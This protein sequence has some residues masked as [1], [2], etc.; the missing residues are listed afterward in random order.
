MGENPATMSGHSRTIIAMSDVTAADSHAFQVDLRGLVDLL[1]HHLYS[2]PRV[3]VRE[4]L[5]NAVDAVTARRAL[6]GETPGTGPGPIVRGCPRRNPS[7][8][9]LCNSK[10]QTRLPRGVGFWSPRTCHYESGSNPDALFDVP[11][12]SPSLDR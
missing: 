3:F 10:R 8:T 9:H 6:S 1:S 11:I 7:R 4:L 5:Q 2:S 12:A